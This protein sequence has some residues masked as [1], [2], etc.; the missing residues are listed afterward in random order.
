MYSVVVVWSADEYHKPSVAVECLA[1]LLRILDAPIRFSD[2]MS[3]ILS[4]FSFFP[5]SLQVDSGKVP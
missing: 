2:K 1:T 3:A 5:R 4:E